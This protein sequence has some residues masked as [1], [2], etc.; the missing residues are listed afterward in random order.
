MSLLYNDKKPKPKA[1]GR[2][3]NEADIFDKKIYVHPERPGSTYMKDAFD[4]WFIKNESTNGY[5]VA[6]KDPDGS[7]K[8]KLNDEL[9]LPSTQLRTDVPA[10]GKSFFGEPEKPERYIKDS[11]E[12]KLVSDAKPEPK[13]EPKV[14]SEIFTN[15]FLLRQQFKESSFNPKSVSPAGAAGLAQIMP[16]VKGDAVKA[17]I[18]K[19]TDS[20]YD[21]EVSAK[22]QKWYM[23]DLYNASFINKPNQ[24]NEIRLAKTLAAYNHGR[25]NFLEYLNEQKKKGVDI[26]KGKE[27]MNELPRE[28][29]DYVNKILYKSNPEFER[30]Y[31]KAVK[32]Y[33]FKKGGLLYKK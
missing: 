18:I 11:S 22:I 15:D 26:Y 3:I 16:D 32:T 13:A 9:R 21:P 29:R 31:A 14:N 8:S 25:G 19:S 23:T 2:T 10:Y 30:Q 7:R 12:P 4:D 17:G 6:I 28:T 1:P 33:K 27:W 24:S 20:L 5:Y